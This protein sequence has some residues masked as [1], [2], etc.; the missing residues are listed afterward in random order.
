MTT[1]QRKTSTS[2]DD[3]NLD[4]VMG[5]S[6]GDFS[7]LL[8][9]TRK[10]TRKKVEKA[11]PVEA[12][13]PIQL[14]GRLP[15]DI[16]EPTIP[17]LRRL[18][19]KYASRGKVDLDDIVDILVKNEALEEQLESTLD[20]CEALEIEVVQRSAAD[21]KGPKKVPMKRSEREL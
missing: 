18:I 15:S 3:F 14:G 5:D 9:P 6:F 16:E 13:L 12:K 7:D 21:A 1:T 20:Y 2:S 11:A 4:S 19:K 8:Q 17:E 10:V